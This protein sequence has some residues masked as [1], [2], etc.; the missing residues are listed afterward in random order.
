MGLFRSAGS[1]QR[2]PCKSKNKVI[3]IRQYARAE[4]LLPPIW[5][6]QHFELPEEMIYLVTQL[7][8]TTLSEGRIMTYPGEVTTDD[9]QTTKTG[10]QFIDVVVGD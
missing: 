6:A 2:I 3:G 4:S 5:N 10:L 9:V 1:K 7:L 8:L